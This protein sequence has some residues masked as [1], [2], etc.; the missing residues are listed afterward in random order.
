MVEARGVVV[1]TVLAA[2]V[3]L[4]LVAYAAS[5]LLPNTLKQQACQSGQLPASDC[6]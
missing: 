6:D 1:A 2:L 3:V 4:G 5:T